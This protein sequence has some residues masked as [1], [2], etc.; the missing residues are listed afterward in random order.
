MSIATR[1]AR[2]ERLVCDLTAQ[3]VRCYD[4][5]FDDP[6]RAE[7]AGARPRGNDVRHFAMPNMRRA[8]GWRVWDTVPSRARRD[9][10]SAADG[11]RGWA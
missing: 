9:W 1:L 2:I 4:C 5:P 11:L 3:P 6:M 7:H 10:D 8:N